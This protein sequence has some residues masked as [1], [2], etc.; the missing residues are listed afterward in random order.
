MSVLTEGPPN[1][2]TTLATAQT[3]PIHRNRS[4]P[5]LATTSPLLTLT[6]NANLRA[7]QLTAGPAPLDADDTLYNKTGRK[8]DGAG[9]FRDAVASTR[10]RVV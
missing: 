2:L 9:I 1:P 3:T 4:L 6:R 10:S 5:S 7:A 8:V